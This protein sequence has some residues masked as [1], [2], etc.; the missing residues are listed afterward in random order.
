M[1]TK[2]VQVENLRLY[3]ALVNLHQLWFG[4]TTHKGV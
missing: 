2:V 3:E 4:G 1:L